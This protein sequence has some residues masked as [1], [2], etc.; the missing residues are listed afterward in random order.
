MKFNTNVMQTEATPHVLFQLYIKGAVNVVMECY[1]ATFVNNDKRT[2][3]LVVL[4][5][6]LAQVQCFRDTYQLH[7]QDRKVSQVRKQHNQAASRALQ[8]SY[9]LL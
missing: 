7:L 9:S 8:S 1:S 2:V 3:L 5:C 4:L 6:S